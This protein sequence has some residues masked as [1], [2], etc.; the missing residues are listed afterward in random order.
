MTPIPLAQGASAPAGTGGEIAGGR[1][2]LTDVLYDSF[3]TVTGEAAGAFELDST[4]L[5]SGQGSAALS[6]DITSPTTETIDENGAGPYSAS[7]TTLDFQNDCGGELLLG[8]A[9][10][11]IDDSGPIP[12]MTLWGSIDI[13]DPFPTSI[14]IEV[15]FLLVEP[16]GPGDPI[17]SDRFEAP[18]SGS[19]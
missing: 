12:M 5:S 14:P 15:R 19:L 2:E 16:A 10:Y 4:D 18:Q 13:T 8:N 3:L 1:W 11:S 7:G 17:F 6:V 9:E